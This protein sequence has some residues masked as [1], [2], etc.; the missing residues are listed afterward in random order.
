MDEKDYAGEVDELLAR[1]SLSIHLVG[2]NYGVVPDGPSEKSVVVLQNELAIE[3]SKNR[4]LSRIIWLPK[5]TRS[6]SERQQKFIEKLLNDAEAQFGADLITGELEGLKG[7]VLAAIKKIETPE[8]AKEEPSSG[9]GT[10]L[11]YLICDERDR[12]ASI[13]LRKFLK[14]QGFEAQIPVFEGDAATVRQANQELLAQCDALI[15]F[16]G[17]GDEGWKRSIE[18]ELKK[19]SSYRHGKALPGRYTYLAEPVTD[20]KKDLIDLEEPNLIH[21]FEGF[22]ELEMASF[23]NAIVGAKAVAGA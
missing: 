1:C 14:A 8:P 10:K 7:A 23:M 11:I 5:E 3:H 18:N 16:Y 4:G 9:S 20:D 15:L 13:P 19:M 21:G 12:K 17:A 2:R 6:E 22:A